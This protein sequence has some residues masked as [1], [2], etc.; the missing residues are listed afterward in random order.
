VTFAILPVEEVSEEEKAGLVVVALAAL[1]SQAAL[2]RIPRAR[3]RG[4]QRWRTCP[5]IS[6]IELSMDDKLFRRH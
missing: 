6:P 5:S 2:L 3:L 4:N 1:I